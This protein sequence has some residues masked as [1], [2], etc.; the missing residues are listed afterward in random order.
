M[1]LAS[2][3]G[4]LEVKPSIAATLSPMPMDLSEAVLAS[5]DAGYITDEKALEMHLKWTELAAEPDFDESYM[6]SMLLRELEAQQMHAGAVAAAREKYL[7]DQ[8]RLQE[9][10]VTRR[11]TPTETILE[12]PTT[13]TMPIDSDAQAEYIESLR[14]SG[15][16]LPGW[17]LPVGLAAAVGAYFIFRP[18]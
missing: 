8:Q 11:H 10:P 15:G 6:R 9:E 7:L 18:R 4:L 1:T 2:T 17:V 5:A 3:M 12:W 16:G 14:P 13:S